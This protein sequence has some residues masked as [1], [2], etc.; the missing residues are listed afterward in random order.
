[1]SIIKKQTNLVF[2]NF[3]ILVLGIV[4]FF[5]YTQSI[6]NTEHKAWLN[7][8]F[9]DTKPLL[10][11][12]DKDI[13]DNN[14]KYLHI[15]AITW[16]IYKELMA[17]RVSNQEVDKTSKP[18]Q[19]KTISQIENN[20]KNSWDLKTFYS[21][22]VLDIPKINLVWVRAWEADFEN[23]WWQLDNGIAHLK[24]SALPWELGFWYLFDHSSRFTNPEQISRY[25]YYFSNLDQLSV[26]DSVFLSNTERKKK[27]E[28]K[29]TDKFIVEKTDLSW[30]IAEP[31]K[32]KFALQTCYPRWMNEK[33]LIVVV[34]FN[35]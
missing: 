11:S 8:P 3:T 19:E 21:Y 23:Y 7:K 14:S 16:E 6:F 33:R 24:N 29:V 10:I 28:Y 15:T 26:W 13:K 32:K 25:A 2:L 17:L 22:I 5:F 12:F 34:E 30:F 20:N 18:V 9:S 27:Y 31:W 4:S 1:M 35:D